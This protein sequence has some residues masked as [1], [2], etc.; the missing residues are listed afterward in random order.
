M[1]DA[2]DALD[3]AAAGLSDW[4]TVKQ[5][6]GVQHAVGDLLDTLAPE[7]P[8][9]RGA[10]PAAPALRRLRTPR[11]CILQTATRA[12]SVSWFPSTSLQPTLG[13][14]QVI[15]WRGTVSRPGSA[16]RESGGAVALS[17]VV[18]EP[19]Q[20]SGDAWG[21]RGADG[22]VIDTPALAERCK[23]LLDTLGGRAEGAR[24]TREGRRNR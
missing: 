2:I 3:A 23:A 12:V 24:E 8:P 22:T 1:H 20:M 6:N 7:R 5:R 9:A 10:E 17:Q 16:H 11:G 4:P 19:A 14:L 15:V 21:W 13:E 18:L